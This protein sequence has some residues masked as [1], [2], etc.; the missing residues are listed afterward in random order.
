[1]TRAFSVA[2]AT[3]LLGCSSASTT[4]N[5]P[6]DNDAGMVADSAPQDAGPSC[7]DPTTAPDAP[8]GALSWT[9]SATA[10]RKRNHHTTFVVPNDDGTA[11]LVAAGGV[12]GAQVL[13]DVDVAPLASDGT[14]GA[15][16]SSAK[17]PKYV[18][19]HTGAL[20]GRTIVIGGGNSLSGFSNSVYS[21]N[22]AADG[23]ISAWTMGPSLP[24]A[25]MHGGAFAKDGAVTMMG[26]YAG[27]QVWDYIV[28]ATV[29]PDGTV[30]AWAPAGQLPH[31]RSH[32]S[33]NEVDGYVFITGGLDQPATS[34][35]PVLKDTLRAR[36]ASDGTLTEWTPQTDLPDAICTHSGFFWGGYLYVVGGIDDASQLKKV[37]RA[38]IVNHALGAWE[39]V[40]D[41]P[42]ARGHVHQVPVFAGHVYSVSGAIDF[43][44]NS[45]DQIFV[46]SFL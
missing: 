3:A 7:T 2:L 33:V 10:S 22:V 36:I 30:G 18:G 16:T 24:H 23:T 26:G 19:G 41:L 43:D 4:T 27:G 25:G 38:P 28:R 35:P 44:L 5:P 40:A 46:G 6:P 45:T 8:C 37:Y 39:A 1:M 11:W 20:S 31:Q 34:N 13:G 12:N 14:V 21:A 17:L 9:A 32:F 42:L 15:F 29:A